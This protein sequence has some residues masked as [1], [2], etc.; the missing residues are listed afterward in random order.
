MYDPCPVGWRVPDTD[1]EAWK[2]FSSISKGIDGGI[3]FSTQMSDL[4]AY[5]PYSGYISQDGVLMDVNYQTHI[6]TANF[7]MTLRLVDRT[8]EN[9]YTRSHMSQG[10]S[11]RCIKDAD[12]KVKT[13]DVEDIIKAD[14][15]LKVPG[16]L[17]VLD[18]TVM[19]EVGVVYSKFDNDPK[20]GDENVVAV[21]TQN[22][23][24]G[25][26]SVTVPGLAPNTKYWIRT[27]AKGGYNVR[28]GV[29]REVYTKASADNEGYG[30][31]DFEW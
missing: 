20:I 12:F 7:S 27:Y 28:Y 26:F 2:G 23:S 10:L 29:V 17:T 21:G 31:E 19:D 8:V 22:V 4:Y 24:S 16:V 1:V 5:Y 9:N 6:R 15:Y 14:V 18:S 11:V 30:S 13:G 3:L 25:D